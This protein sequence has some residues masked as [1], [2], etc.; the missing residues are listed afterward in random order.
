MGGVRAIRYLL[1]VGVLGLCLWAPFARADEVKEGPYWDAWALYEQG[2]HA[3][4]VA[5]WQR[6]IDAGDAD[7]YYGMGRYYWKGGAVPKN[8]KR[9]IEYFLKGAKLRNLRSLFMLGYIYQNGYF[10]DKNARF[11]ECY[12]LAA[13]SLGS[14]PAMFNLSRLYLRE[15]KKSLESLQWLVFAAERGD[16]LALFRLGEILFANPLREKWE[17][18]MYFLLASEKGHKRATFWIEELKAA[19]D[20]SS[21]NILELARKKANEWRPKAGPPPIEPYSIPNDCWPKI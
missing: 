18:A 20:A 1:A 15:I 5:V 3:G 7:G 11:A 19:K 4:A 6:L 2:D 16:E 21:R 8:E 12:Y 9:A 13:A 10:V 17:G 14:P